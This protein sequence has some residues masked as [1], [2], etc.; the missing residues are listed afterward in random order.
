MIIFYKESKS[1]IFLLRSQVKS[2]Q[3]LCSIDPYHRAMTENMQD[4]TQ[5]FIGKHDKS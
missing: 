3:N 4:N 2:S 5:G 1:K